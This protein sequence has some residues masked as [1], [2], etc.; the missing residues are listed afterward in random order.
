[1]Y[2]IQ[3]QSVQYAG[4]PYIDNKLDRPLQHSDLQVA[5][6]M[7]VQLRNSYKCEWCIWNAETNELMLGVDLFKKTQKV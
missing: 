5:K 2:D 1:M 3:K 4:L 7:V 6:R